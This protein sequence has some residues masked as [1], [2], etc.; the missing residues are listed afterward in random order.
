[1]VGSG[2]LPPF[3]LVL[4]GPGNRDD[5][6][7]ANNAYAATLAGPVL[8]A[9]RDE[10]GFEA[11][12]IGLGASLGGLAML[13]AQRRYPAAFA[14]L[15]LQSGSF[16]RPRLDPQESGFRLFPTDNP[17]RR[18]GRGVRVRRVT[19]ADSAHLWHRSRRT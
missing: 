19:R 4:L 8:A 6:Y 2:T 7:S 14:G 15:F 3:H 16:F 18:A 17:V 13:H 11:P 12:V 9:L 1:M 5:W 10:L